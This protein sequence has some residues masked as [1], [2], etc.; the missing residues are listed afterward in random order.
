MGI[1]RCG[2]CLMVVLGMGT[3]LARG[4]AQSWELQNG[5]WRP[6]GGE[7]STR[8][9]SDATLD[10]AELLLTH[11]GYVAAMNMMLTWIKQN[12]KSPLMDRAILL[13]AESYFQNGDRLTAFYECDHL[14]DDFSDS[15]LYYRA[16]EMQY[17]IAEEFLDGYRRRLFGMA[18]LSAEGE[19]V[20]MLYR[21]QQRSPGSPLAEKALLRT[22]D[23]YYATSQF[24]LSGDTY[25][26]YVKQYPRS[27]MVPRARLRAAF[28]SLAQFRGLPY[29]ATPLLD[30]R[31]QLIDLAMAYPDLAKEEN[32]E[33]VMQ[34]IDKS[35][36]RKILHTANFYVRTHDRASAV[37][38]YRFLM[39]AYPDSPEAQEAKQA[40]A[41]MPA[42]AMKNSPPPTG[43][44]YAPAT[45]P[46]VE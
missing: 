38:Q 3:T 20:E 13:L 39:Q 23:Y 8:P 37:Y 1:G 31:T 16:L 26:A 22:A 46:S 27:P 2:V 17:K 30:A 45:Q 35:F 28:S 43:G 19:A 44:D 21:I 24:D 14:M 10:R 12:K 32:L 34:R 41:K 6:V 25:T 36:A 18:V 42:S 11:N 40:L 9:V 15:P 33:D 7:A 4:E 29:D 5:Q